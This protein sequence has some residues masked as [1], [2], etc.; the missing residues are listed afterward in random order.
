MAFSLNGFA[1]G[2]KSFAKRINDHIAYALVVYTLM[3]IFVVSPKLEGNGLTVFPYFLL[4]ALVAMAI[5]PCRNLDR[6]WQLI[7]QADTMDSGIS[8]RYNFDRIKLW[9]GAV[10]FPL[11]LAFAL[12]VIAGE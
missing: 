5:P 12:S 4:V 9:V 2:H 10:G 11:L 6:K 1:G 8:R 3:L 7:D